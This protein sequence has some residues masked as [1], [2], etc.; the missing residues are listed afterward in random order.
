MRLAGF[1]LAFLTI[2]PAVQAA[3]PVFP[4]GAV[5]FRKSNPPEQDWER[6]H[7]TAAQVGMNMFRH[8]VLWSAVETAPGKYDWREYD[9]MMQLEAQNGI[10]AVL[11]EFVTSAPE[12]AWTQFPDA[13]FEAQDGYRGVPEYSGS[14]ATGGFPGLCLD[15]PKV[16]AR[17]E[18]SCGR[19]PNTTRITRRFTGTTS[20]TK[21]TPAA[22]R[23]HTSRSPPARTSRTSIA[24]PTSGAC[25]ATVLRRSTSF[26]V[27]SHEIR[28]PGGGE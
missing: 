14:S 7:K 3:D 10:R 5:Y 15:N 16:R 28:Q 6:D 18:R 25:T 4:Y 21:E 12:W 13:R 22:A 19:L 9:R 2:V 26:Q 11:A 8:W 23:A 17:A 1:L 27:A 20:G 24:E